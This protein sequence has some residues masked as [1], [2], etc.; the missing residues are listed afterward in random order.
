VPKLHHTSVGH[1]ISNKVHDMVQLAL[2]MNNG[3]KQSPTADDLC[4]QI[5]SMSSMFQISGFQTGF[6]EGIS[7]VL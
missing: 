2:L 3:K 5:A 6:C 1:L 4:S 7:G